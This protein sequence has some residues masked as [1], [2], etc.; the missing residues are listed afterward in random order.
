M[1]VKVCLCLNISLVFDCVKFHD[2]PVE[3]YGL[4]TARN[5]STGCSADP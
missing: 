5:S 1:E 2:T 4:V 3:K